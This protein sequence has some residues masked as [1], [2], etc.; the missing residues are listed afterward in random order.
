MAQDLYQN[1]AEVK[2]FYTRANEILGFD[3]AKVSFEGPE[4]TLKQTRITQPAI[5][6]HSVCLVQQLRKKELMPDMA[7]GHSLGEYSALYAA[8]AFTFEDGLQLVKIRAEL[9]QKAGESNPGTM[10][11]IIGLDPEKIQ[12][13]CEEASSLGVVQVANF[14]SPSQVVISGSIAGVEKAVELVKAMGAK[15]AVPLVVSGAFHSPLMESARE[16]LEQALN[17]VEIREARFPVYTNVEA[18]PVTK[19]EDIKYY[20]REQLTSPVR[21][22]EI[23]QN[24]IRHGASEFYE[25]GPGNVLTGLLRRINREVVGTTV[26]DVE[27]LGNI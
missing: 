23:I 13:A 7:A 8:G 2:D 18:N 5:F 14:N 26:T 24:M 17:E 1:Y 22:V 16:G 27:T 20:L 6:V 3:L 11:A 12:R 19:P 25:I 9:M 21:W 15:R 10:A 4:D